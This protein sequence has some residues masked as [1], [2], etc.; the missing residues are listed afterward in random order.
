VK[1]KSD[2]KDKSIVDDA[3]ASNNSPNPFVTSGSKN[4]EQ[5]PITSFHP[6]LPRRVME[7]PGGPK[8]SDNQMSL[9]NE[10]N[11]LTVGQNIRLNGEIVACETLVV[12][13]QVEAKLRDARIIEVS[14]GGCFEGSAD[15]TEASI[16]GK[17][18]GTLVAKELLTIHNG[19]HVEGSI[20]YG[21]IIIEA[22]GTITG[23]M[24]SIEKQ[25]T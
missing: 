14:E 25:E 18:I 5:K 17:F 16:S 10:A 1:K 23:D 11:K 22:G 8:R 19:G 12:E 7:I 3:T 2:V 20:R 21:K 15:V 9:S 4:T 13:G 6:E 24:A